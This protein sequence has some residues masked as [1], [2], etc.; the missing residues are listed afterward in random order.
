ML[1]AWY[2]LSPVVTACTRPTTTSASDQARRAPRR[3]STIP[4]STAS[5]AITGTRILAVV[6]T[7]PK[8][9]PSSTA[10]D[11]APNVDPIR[12]QP[13]SLSPPGTSGHP[14]D[15]GTHVGGAVHGPRH[16]RG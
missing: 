3:P 12:R 2:R 10:R 5:P 6:H 11:S 1:N 16:A 14:T 7:S 9:D 13:R 4:L 8:A 15:P